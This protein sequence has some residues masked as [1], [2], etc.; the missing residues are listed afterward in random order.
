MPV[1]HVA[2]AAAALLAAS[3]IGLPAVADTSTDATPKSSF[4]EV[5]AGPDRPLH[6]VSAMS[7]PINGGCSDS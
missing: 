2:K 6:D 1:Q 3:A 4:V 5:L 7:D